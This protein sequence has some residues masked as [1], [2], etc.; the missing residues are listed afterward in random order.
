MCDMPSP[1]ESVKVF[2]RTMRERGFDSDTIIEAVLALP[3][4]TVT[5][6]NGVTYNAKKQAE[7]RARKKAAVV[8]SVTNALPTRTRARGIVSSSSKEIPG[9][10][11]K[12]R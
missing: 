4:V 3:D 10:K 2:V 5:R 6:G 1:I 8:T 11:E 12:K 7:Y 9:K